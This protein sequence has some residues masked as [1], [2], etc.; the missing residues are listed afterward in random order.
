M[1]E[2]YQCLHLV[3]LCTL[4]VMAPAVFARPVSIIAFNSKPSNGQKEL[5][6]YNPD[7][8]IKWGPIKDGTFGISSSGG[9]A[10]ANGGKMEMGYDGYVYMV[11]DK[12][13]GGIT[14]FDPDT[15]EIFVVQQN[16]QK[17]YT[18]QNQSDLTFGPDIDDDGIPD[19][20]VC[21]GD[22]PVPMV[23]SYTSSSGYAASSG[24]VFVAFD[25]IKREPSKL[26]RLCF[27]PDVTSDG[28]PELFC[29]DEAA[30]KIWVYDGK[31]GAPL[32]SWGTGAVGGHDIK[33]NPLDGRIYLLDGGSSTKGVR[34]YLPD[35]TDMNY[36]GINNEGISS[37]PRGFDNA[38]WPDY[39]WYVSLRNNNEFTTN[40]AIWRKD[41]LLQEL[42]ELFVEYGTNATCEWPSVQVAL[43]R[44][45]YDPAPAADDL[46]VPTTQ[47]TVSWNN[48]VDATKCE[49][50][51]GTDPNV[52]N[53]TKITIL[54]P[55]ARE[56]VAIPAAY[57]PLSD[58]TDYYW[59]VDSYYGVPAPAP[60]DP[61]AIHDPNAII[62]PATPNIFSDGVW[63]FRANHNGA[64]VVDVADQY[65]WQGKDGVPGQATLAFMPF[66]TDDGLFPGDTLTYQWTQLAGPA[67]TINPDD[68]VLKD[69]S[70]V[71]T[72]LSTD[73]QFQLTVSDGD[74]TT[75]VTARVVLAADACAASSQDPDFSYAS[76][77]INKDCIVDLV[78]FT[79]MALNWLNCNSLDGCDI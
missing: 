57:L 66:V 30:L 55:A 53:G 8:T 13:G 75:S 65:L 69:I 37:N 62:T 73:Y 36:G 15:G 7:G 64:P 44:V 78:D 29:L 12:P 18:Y 60:Q 76:G 47:T 74:R 46:Y 14:K 32:Y 45:L 56:T 25:P 19:L 11:A 61:N 35:G 42:G 38:G 59:A 9:A 3:I 49:L 70:L 31:T 16:L 33:Y 63:H 21:T 71:L 23:L 48:Y 79:E 34:S 50:Y 6:C 17:P 72:E 58:Q 22:R 27:G 51:F 39:E 24:A 77:D 68:A 43:K 26:G 1:L 40:P 5:I 67:V 2:K 10:G 4:A 41:S 52:L 28:T 54:N 20:Y